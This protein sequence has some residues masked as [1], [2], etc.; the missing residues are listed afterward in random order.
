MK[1]LLQKRVSLFGKEV[2]VLL[3]A[4]IGVMAFAS[5][6]LVPYLS[7]VITGMVTVDSPME[8]A[9][10]SEY[11][12][13]HKEF[14]VFGGGSFSYETYQRNNGEEPIEVYK[15]IHVIKAPEGDTWTGEELTSLVLYDPRY[16]EVAPEGTDILDALYHIKD[17]G[18]LVALADVE[19]ENTNV[20]RLI[21]APE[22][23]AETYTHSPGEEGEIMNE[24]TIT[25]N[26]H[27]APGSYELM[28]FYT[29]DLSTVSEVTF[30]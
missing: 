20:L 10:D 14:N 21:Y 3:I 5:A 4:V 25:T 19:T 30:D 24:I 18:T 23:V 13:V 12:E 11:T 6:A 29:D 1:K 9:F 15:V 16:D 7:N 22:G 17:D 28:L 27:I 2:S 26:A 8:L